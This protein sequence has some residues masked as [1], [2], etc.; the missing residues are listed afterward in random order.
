[1]ISLSNKENHRNAID[2][3]VIFLFYIFFHNLDCTLYHNTLQHIFI[4]S[5]ISYIISIT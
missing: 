1:M 4:F 2:N 3:S 5:L